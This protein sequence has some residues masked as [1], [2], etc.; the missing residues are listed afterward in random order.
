MKRETINY[1]A[2]G[3]F[4]LL[5]LAAFFAL[6]LAITRPGGG[7]TDRYHVFY[8]DV[9]GIKY[10]TPVLYQ[11][12]QVGQ[13]EVVAPDQGESGL[14]YRVDFSVRKGWVVPADSV[15]RVTMSGLL[16]AVSIDIRGG[17]SAT[18][19]APG[20]EVAGEERVDLFASMDELAADLRQ[21]LGTS[22]RPLLDSLNSRL[23]QLSG[24]VEDEVT[25]LL[26]GLRDDLGRLSG[27]LNAS[28]DVLAT[29]LNDEN[30]QHVENALANMDAVSKNLGTVSADIHE[31]RARLDGL[32]DSVGALISD[33]Q[34]DLAGALHDLRRSMRVLADNVDAV[35]YNLEGA[36]RNLNEFSRQIRQNP[37]IL[38]GG[39]APRDSA[40]V[41]R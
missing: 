34:D 11:G 32:L 13:V 1:T 10:G 15:A 21:L 2:V 14:R 29:M 20:A 23:E 4:V 8:R 16:S 26:R 39:S 41:A 19:L 24:T 36:T 9:A 12:Y 5:M 17:D 7:A 18:M 22:V 30:A 28:A 3:L 31:T 40:T 38:L 25:A 37:G 33:N 27:K 6:L 35:V